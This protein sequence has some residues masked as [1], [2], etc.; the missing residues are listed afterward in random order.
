MSQQGTTLSC[1]M[2]DFIAIEDMLNFQI[3]FTLE[4]WTKRKKQRNN[5][6][7]R[8]PPW[9][10]AVSSAEAEVYLDRGCK[11]GTDTYSSAQKYL[12]NVDVMLWLI[13]R[14]QTPGNIQEQES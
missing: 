5:S 6:L 4:I 1:F 14:V 9:T 10:A 3:N 2:N 13:W 7:I 8:F 11:Q 12:D